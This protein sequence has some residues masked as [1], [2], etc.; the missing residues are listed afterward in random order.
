MANFLSVWGFFQR[1]DNYRA[2]GEGAEE[3]KSHSNKTED[4]ERKEELW[5]EEN[6]SG[7]R[8]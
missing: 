3:E 5:M 4:G 2:R 1:T 8:E 7:K 6:L